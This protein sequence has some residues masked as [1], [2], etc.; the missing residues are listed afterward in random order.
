MDESFYRCHRSFFVNMAYISEYSS[1]SISLADGEVVY[2][3]KGKYPE[4]VKTYMRFLRNGGG[5]LD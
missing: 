2:L 5:S 1:D 4:F 3:A